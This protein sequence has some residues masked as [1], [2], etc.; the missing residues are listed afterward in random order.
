MS[1]ENRDQDAAPKAAACA[2][3]PLRWHFVGQLQTNKVRSV[4]RY[5]DVVQ[6]VDRPRLVTRS[7]RTPWPRPGASSAVLVQVALDARPARPASGAASA[8]DG[9]AELADLV[10]GAPRLRLRRPDDRRAARRTVRR[11]PQA[12]FERLLDVST[13]LR[14]DHPA[15]NMVSAGMSRR[16]RGRPSRP[17]RHTC[18]SAR[19]YS[20]SAPGARVTSQEVGPQQ[21][22]WSL[23]YERTDLVDRGTWQSSRRRSRMAG[24]M[25]K[26]AV[27]LGLVEDDDRYDD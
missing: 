19:R 11:T 6:S 15:A 20:E 21:K 2:D 14:A 18:A 26:M 16:P 8:P 23:P 13:D 24:A 4:A 7:R 10:A 17:A 27:Y 12:A 25:R 9:I 5:A 22:I 3:L 1:R